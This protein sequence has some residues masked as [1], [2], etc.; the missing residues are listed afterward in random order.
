MLISV[1][2]SSLN[3]G[4]VNSGGGSYTLD[5]FIYNDQ[6]DINITSV[7]SS[8]GQFTS[9]LATGALTGNTGTVFH[10]TYTP[11]GAGTTNATL[12]I[13]SNAIN[14]P[15]VISLTGTGATGK[16]CVSNPSKWDFGSQKSGVATAEKIFVLKNTGTVTVTITALTY[17]A[18]FSAGGT[19]PALNYTLTVGSTVNVG[20]KFTPSGT[21]Y[22]DKTNGFI[23][24]SDATGSPLNVELAGTGYAITSAFILNNSS[25]LALAAMGNTVKQFSTTSLDTEELCQFTKLHNFEEPGVEKTFERFFLKYE[26]LG[27]AALTVAATGLKG[28]SSQLKNGTLN[29]GNGAADSK[30]LETSLELIVDGELVEITVTKGISTGPVSI[31]EYQCKYLPWGQL[32]GTSSNPGTLASP[33]FIL[34]NTLGW[35]AAF[36]NTVKKFDSTNLSCEEACSTDKLINLD[37]PTFEKTLFNVQ[38]D[39]ED[40][41]PATLTVQIFNRREPNS[42]INFTMNLGINN[43]NEI[44][45]EIANFQVTEEVMHV[46]FLTG[47]GPGPLSICGWNTQ[48]EPAGEVRKDA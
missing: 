3:F 5:C 39:Y 27:V 24:T 42:P 28:G 14:N 16:L 37:L 6:Y 7:V 31:V 21:G 2:P 33:A 38:V 1:N 47:V 15:I 19:Q 18:P 11:S 22:V 40:L 44:L 12:T 46:K 13:N 4:S 41:G 43:S 9:D 45:R 25:V 8:D 32:L 10:V 20:V 30:V 29:F 35:I 26:N 17:T 34:N 23:I 48:Y 36:G